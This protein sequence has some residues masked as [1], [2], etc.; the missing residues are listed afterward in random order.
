MKEEKEREAR[1]CR[2]N[3]WKRKK[4]EKEGMIRKE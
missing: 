2:R 1:K 4:R 3:E